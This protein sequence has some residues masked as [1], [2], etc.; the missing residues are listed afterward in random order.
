MGHGFNN[1]VMDTLIRFNRMRGRPPCGNRAP[2]TPASRRR[3]WWNVS[4]EAAGLTAHDLGRDK[5]IERIWEWKAES[6]GN[7]PPT[8]PPRLVAGLGT[9]VSRWTR[10][11]PRPS[12][13]FIRLYEEGLIYRGKRLVAGTPSCTAV[14]DLR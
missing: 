10:D 14:S 6:G 4:S 13:V 2:I 8:A 9:G 5:F 11:C 1:T 7:I 12:E 3:W